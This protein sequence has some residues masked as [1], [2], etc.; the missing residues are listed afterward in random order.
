MKVPRPSGGSRQSSGVGKIFVKYD[1]PE[2]ARKAMQALAGRK[3]A[4]RTVVVTYFSEVC[5]PWCCGVTNNRLTIL[6]RKTSKSTRGRARY[7]GMPIRGQMLAQAMCLCF[8]TLTACC[9]ITSALAL[10][11]WLQ[12][13]FRGSKACG[14]PTLQPRVQQSKYH[15]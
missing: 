8:F 15:R 11:I 1:G 14:Q 13:G 5:G 10:T 6:C 3:F 7:L 4:D 2:S 12:S 9:T